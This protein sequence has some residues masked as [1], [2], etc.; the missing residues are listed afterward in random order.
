MLSCKLIKYIRKLRAASLLL[1]Y[2]L[3]TTYLREIWKGIQRELQILRKL[4]ELRKLQKFA[5]LVKKIIPKQKL[6]RT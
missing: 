4:Q 3:Y 6:L 2:V 5:I 1:Q